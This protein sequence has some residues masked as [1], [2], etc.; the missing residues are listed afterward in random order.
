MQRL[1]KSIGELLDLLLVKVL[2]TIARA[3]VSG[4]PASVS[5]P[6]SSRLSFRAGAIDRKQLQ[7]ATT[8]T[9]QKNAI[10]TPITAD[11]MPPEV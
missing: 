5:P 10:R 7:Y 1:R 9:V 8:M 6:L 3:D 4:A 11:K 2:V